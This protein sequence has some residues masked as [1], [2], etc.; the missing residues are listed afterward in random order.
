MRRRS[1]LQATALLPAWRLLA[2]DELPA[3]LT[4]GQLGT[5]HAHAAGK[6]A[7]VRGLGEDFLQAGVAEADPQRR[8]RLAAGKDFKDAR[9]RD[10]TELLADPAVRA[11]VIE[12][13]LAAATPTAWRALQAGKHVHLDKPGGDDHAAFKALRLEAERRGLAFQ[14]GYM[15]RHNPGIAW[16]RQ[17]VRA[18]WLGEL[19]RVEAA[20]NKQAD[21]ALR[22]QLLT[23]PGHGMLEL[24]CHLVDVVIDLLGTPLRVASEA[25][26]TG[27]DALPDRQSAEF[28]YA[29]AVARITCDHADPTAR[30]YL[31]V[32]GTNG[33]VQLDP[34][35][36]RRLRHRFDAPPAGLPPGEQTLTLAGNGGRYDEEFRAFARMIRG[37][38]P[39]WDAAHDIAVHAAAR[40]AAGL[41]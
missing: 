26:R 41:A 9:W 36:S 17:A 33:W 2:A 39:K 31:R 10:E 34:L 11:V 3:R 18:G 5:T 30:R 28:R 14:M 12:T 20:M 21:A 15:L 32:E 16:V 22:R 27:P 35:E 6:Y 8:A 37:E 13:D 24:G 23:Y 1:F 4:V 38:R 29:N 40:R 19:R 7:A 25:E